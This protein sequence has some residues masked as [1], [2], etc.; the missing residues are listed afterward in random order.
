MGGTDIDLRLRLLNDPDF[1]DRLM[2]DHT[3]RHRLSVEEPDIHTRMLAEPEFRA[4]RLDDPDIQARLS[5]EGPYPEGRYQRHSFAVAPSAVRAL[6]SRADELIAELATRLHENW[7]STRLLPNGTYAARPKRAIDEDWI[8][9]HGTD[10]VDIA[11]MPNHELPKDWQRNNVESARVTV[12]RILAELRAGRDPGRTEFVAHAY[13]EIH[14]EWLLRNDAA[15]DVQMR[16]YP[17]LSEDQKALDRDVYHAVLDL[18]A[19]KLARW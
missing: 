18:V 10:I 6:E 3:H 5:A 2:Q 16:L 13:S 19:E 15:T 8:A 7:R 11:N 9:A 17:D 1:R 12:E 4:R 14:E